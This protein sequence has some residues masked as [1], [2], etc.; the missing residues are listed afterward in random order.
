MF[1]KQEFTN[2]KVCH[3]GSL[4]VPVFIVLRSPVELLNVNND[5]VSLLVDY[6]LIINFLFT[7]QQFF[8]GLKNKSNLL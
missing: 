3:V 5:Y 7:C 6:T 4:N 2:H 8:S 1:I